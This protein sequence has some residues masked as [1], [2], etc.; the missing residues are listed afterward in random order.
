MNGQIRAH[1]RSYKGSKPEI[2][3]KAAEFNALANRI[4]EHVNR[5]IR[6]CPDE[7]Q[8]YHYSAIANELGIDEE[9]VREAISDGGY[10]GITIKKP[11]EN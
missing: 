3:R 8:Q 11:S 6:E 1:H 4:A 10:N 9:L 2:R 7:I 5:K